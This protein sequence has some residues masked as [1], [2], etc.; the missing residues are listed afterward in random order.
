MK[1]K[2]PL[3]S[4]PRH[5]L[6]G[7]RDSTAYLSMNLK[8]TWQ[9]T[10]IGR[11]WING[12]DALF[13]AMLA[14]L[15]F[16]IENTIGL[17][18]I[19]LVSGIPLIGG[20]LSAIPDAAIVFLGAFLIPR[21]GAILLFATILL[22]L[23]TVTVSFGPPGIYKILIGLMLGLLFELLLVISR[24]NVSYVVSTAVVFAASI[25]VTYLAWKLFELPGV[26]QLEPQIPLLMAIYFVEGG[27]GAGLGY[28]LYTKRLS[29]LRSV[30]KLR[31]G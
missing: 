17:V 3:C 28:L 26:E 13:V 11:S 31:E 18:L 14:T 4:P 6:V 30:Q 16:V 2:H 15:S 27:V 10:S 19:P 21:R 9:M 7:T 5:P 12:R 29:R 23:S 22:T 20:T 8:E 25:P 24:Q 1:W